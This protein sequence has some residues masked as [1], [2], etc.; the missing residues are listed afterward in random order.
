MGIDKLDDILRAYREEFGASFGCY[1]NNKSDYIFT[2]DVSK[3]AVL[4]R[5][6]KWAGLRPV[7]NPT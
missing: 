4:Q 2:V 7:S 5:E 1:K 6:I 3:A